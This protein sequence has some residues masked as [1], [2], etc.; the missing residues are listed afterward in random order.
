M[1]C[2]EFALGLV[3]SG[4]GEGV[5]GS[6]SS[7]DIRFLYTSVRIS[8]LTK[9]KSQKTRKSDYFY[10][11][12]KNFAKSPTPTKNSPEIADVTALKLVILA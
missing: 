9:N 3:W 7:K 1:L 6:S 10:L 5:G 12:G 4:E 8:S 2:P 11:S